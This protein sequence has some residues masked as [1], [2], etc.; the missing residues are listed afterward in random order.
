MAKVGPDPSI[1]MD[2]SRRLRYG[3]HEIPRAVTFPLFRAG[4]IA[5][6]VRDNI[7]CPGGRGGGGGGGHALLAD[8][9]D[10]FRMTKDQ[11]ESVYT[12]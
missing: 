2:E 1:S 7:F 6:Y 5:D 10:H 3:H 9:V 12:F 4:I 11:N 8:S